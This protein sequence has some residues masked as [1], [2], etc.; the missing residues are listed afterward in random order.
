[1][2]TIAYDIYIDRDRYAQ[3][4]L[5]RAVELEVAVIDATIESVDFGKNGAVKSLVLADGNR[6][7]G[8]FFIDC[9][10]NRSL[11]GHMNIAQDFVDWSSWLPCDR[12]ASVRTKNVTQPE[13]FTS[14]GA[15]DNGWSRRSILG[16]VAVSSFVYCS[17]Y[18]DD[19][20]ARRFLEENVDGAKAG[21]I[22]VAEMRAG[23]YATP[24]I[25]N[26]VA[27]GPAA[28]TLEPMEV[29]SMHLMHKSIMRL[30]AMLPR[31]KI[32][33]MLSE[34]YNRAT[35]TEVASA[36]DYQIL[37]YTLAGRSKGPFWENVGQV[38]NPDLLQRRIDLF[39]THGRFTRVD[40]ELLSQANWVSSF[41]NL[42]SWPSSY[43]PLADMIDEQRMRNEISRF[44]K[45]VQRAAEQ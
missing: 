42:G 2:A 44:R 28:V 36:R 8:D 3:Y 25:K 19:V 43:D 18:N 33:T 41:I 22:Q 29:S 5:E 9:S 15:H 10:D 14:I 6:I 26:C 23:S 27:I 35:S 32:S 31:K 38:Q 40:H 24:W 7:D 11:I 37:R 21:D 17:Q 30:L 13:L 39:S 1:M 34:E 20:L 12:V 4:M 45:S 16:D